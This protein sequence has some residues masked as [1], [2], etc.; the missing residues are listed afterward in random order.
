MSAPRVLVV[1][2][3]G[4]VLAVSSALGGNEAKRFAVTSSL[5]G[6]K[7]LPLRVHWIARLHHISPSQ[8]LE[9][10]Y[11]IDGKKAWDEKSPPY[12]YGGYSTQFPTDAPWHGGNRLVTSFLTPGFHAFTV[13]V[14]RLTG[15]ALIDTVK[16]RVVAA[17]SPPQDLAG[18]WARMVTP[19]DLKK[20]P[21]GPPPGTWTLHVTSAGW[22]GDGSSTTIPPNEPGWGG[23]D[24]W[25]VRYLKNGNVVM[26]P[27]VVT[28]AN[29]VTGF[30]GVD[31][32]HTWTVMLSSDDQTMRLDPVDTDRCGVRVALLQG[33][34]TREK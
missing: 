24:R 14:L 18:A 21:V 12:Y 13:R 29:Q 23:N 34:W 32:P 27:E 1:V 31:Q 30:C 2:L 28:P 11:F 22:G 10:D 17:P 8:V 16:A 7:V 26:G 5:D 4:G 15:R 25:D 6:K 3:L 9:V 20:G 33:T 19:D